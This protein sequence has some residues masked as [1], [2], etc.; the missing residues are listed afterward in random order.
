MDP[1]RAHLPAASARR[2]D[3]AGAAREVGYRPQRLGPAVRRDH[4]E[5][6]VPARRQGA[7]QQRG[8]RP[9][10]GPRSRQAAGCGDLD[11]LG[12][13]AQG[14]A[15]RADHQ[16]ARQGQADRG[17]LAPFRAADLEPQ[18]R[19]SRRGRG[20]RRPDH[21]GPRRLPPPLPPLLRAEGALA[22]ARPSRALG[23]QRAAAR[24]Q[25]QEDRLV[26]CQGHRARRL[27]RLLAAARGDPRALLRPE[28][29]RC[30]PASGQG[31]RRLLPSDRAER[32]PV[33]AD[34]LPG[35]HARRHDARARAWPR[36]APGAGRPAGSADGVDA[37]DARRD[38]LGVRRAAD[39][40]LAARGRAR[41]G[42]APDPA[43]GQDRGRAQHRGAADRLRRVRAPGARC[44]PGGGADRRRARQGLAR[45]ADREPRPRLPLRR[46]LPRVLELHPALRP[47][48]VL[49]VRLCL[50][51]LPGELAVRGLPGQP[52]GFRGALSAA[53]R[54]RRHASPPGAAGAVRPR[55][56]RPRLLEPRPSHRRGADRPAGRR[57][58]QCKHG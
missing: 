36:R 57:A 15:V 9:A 12:A 2:R 11:R 27:S 19:Q 33:R 18:P 24:G 45:R 14:P 30:R 58:A 41:S 16:H 48:A 10:L 56:E 43:G 42:A 5:P 29:D 54:G 44:P 49:R 55:C 1:R 26:G 21:G 4:G 3:R 47:R 13:R 34:E 31:C 28:L 23:S 39:L 22:R 51:R 20:G 7:H 37:A 38:R 17:R 6:T 46:R 40:P 25:R 50:R 53:A 32:A 35:P 8:L 52:G